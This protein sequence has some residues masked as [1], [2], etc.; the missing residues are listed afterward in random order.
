VIAMLH[1]HPHYTAATDAERRARASKG[2][3]PADVGELD[4]MVRGA[5]RGDDASWNALVARFTARI[6][7][8]AHRHR[9]APHDVDDVLQTTWLRL[10][11]H[12]GSVREPVALG[13][14]LD[15]TAR[16]ESLRLLHST[17]R[18]LPTDEDLDYNEVAEPIAERELVAAERRAALAAGI[19]RLPRAQQRLI[20]ILLAQPTLS[21][22]GIA[23]AL[24]APIGSIG[25]TRGRSLARLRRDPELMRAIGNER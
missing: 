1:H 23:T 6:R 14:W 11:Q 3:P 21:Y 24:E 2:R 16:R 12:I 9:L 20:G 22:A 15:T 19:E 8:V 18:E 17:K 25:P 4:A 10:F 13:A 5:A 7:A